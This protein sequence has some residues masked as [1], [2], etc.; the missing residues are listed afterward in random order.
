MA[1]VDRIVGS[2]MVITWTPDG[3]SAVQLEGDF[4]EFSADRSLD[5][6][7]VTAG[8]ETSRYHKGTVEG[9]EFSITIFDANQTYKDDILPGVVGVLNVKPE[10]TGAGLPEFE[11]NALFTGY[12]ESFPFDGALEIELSGM[13]LGDMVI[14]YGSVQGT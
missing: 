11:M 9:L 1:A 5:T 3:G 2:N 12:N 14:E 8:N 6:V 13:R 7:D 4:T 10:G